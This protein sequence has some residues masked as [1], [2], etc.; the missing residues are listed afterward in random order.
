MPLY[1]YRCSQCGAR[2]ERL[3]RSAEGERDA[4]CPRC[5][6]QKVAKTI[7]PFSASWETPTSNMGIVS[8]Q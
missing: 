8:G 7:S 2:F 4:D 5:G 1:E 6:S 3:V